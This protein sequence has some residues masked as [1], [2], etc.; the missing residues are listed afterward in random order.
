MWFGDMTMRQG[1][2]TG[3]S[4]GP[5]VIT[6]VLRLGRESQKSKRKVAYS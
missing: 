6:Q 1:D 3:L 5:G 4:H 2:Y